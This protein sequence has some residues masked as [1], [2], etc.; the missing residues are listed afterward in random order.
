MV[1]TGFDACIRMQLCMLEGWVRTTNQLADYM[2]KLSSQQVQMLESPAFK[3]WRDEIWQ[4]AALD[5]HYGRRNHDV[6]V[7]KV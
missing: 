1:Y 4:G 2:V 7:E 6:D 3:R 5:D